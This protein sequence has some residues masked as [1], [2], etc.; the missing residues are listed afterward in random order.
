MS[1]VWHLAILPGGGVKGAITLPA[2]RKALVEIQ[3]AG[4]PEGF[5]AIFGISVGGLHASVLGEASSS[6]GQ[7]AQLAVMQRVYEGIKGNKDILGVPFPG[8]I[9]GKARSLLGGGGVYN[10]NG[11]RKLLFS[12]VDMTALRTSGVH[13]EVGAV[14]LE[15]GRYRAVTPQETDYLEFVVA[16][17]A[18]PG[19]AAAVRIQGQRWVDGGVMEIAPLRPVLAWAKQHVP[20][21]DRIELW[22]FATG[23]LK[24]KPMPTLENGLQL[25]MRSLELHSLTVLRKD[26]DRVVRENALIEDNQ[27]EAGHRVIGVR[28]YEPLVHG[29]AA[30][31]FTPEGIKALLALGEETP[32]WDGW[33][34]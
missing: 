19:Q 2:I 8:G 6:A 9:I 11:L 31:D 21:G 17:C 14:S 29:P 33:L 5:A 27:G 25:I 20:A 15:A 26:V 22:V 32:A 28:V 34:P 23:P 30:Y 18:V 4:G 13:V 7:L 10:F 3:A 1:R 16:G 12:H 24:P